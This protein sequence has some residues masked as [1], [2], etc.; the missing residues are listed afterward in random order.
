MNDIVMPKLSDTMTEGRLVSWKKRVGDEV[1]RGEVI[2]EV[3][4]DKAN[5]ELEAYASGVILELKA[6]PGDLVQVGTVIAVVGKPEEKGA[7][8]P[9]VQAPG[10]ETQGAGQAPEPE[11][12]TEP[13]QVPE[14]KPEKERVAQ[15]KGDES[16]QAAP[17]PAGAKEA[18][19]A[20][21]FPMEGEKQA[22]AAPPVPG[23]DQEQP[24]K[25]AAGATEYIHTRAPAPGKEAPEFT[26]SAA[27]RERAAPVVR[28]RAR[29]LG[30][31]LAQVRGSGPDGRILLQ[32]LEGTAGAEGAAAPAQPRKEPAPAAGPRLVEEVRTMSRLRAAVA[33]TVADSWE[34]IPHFSVTMDILMD[35]AEAIRRQLKQGGMRVT[36]ND[37]IVKGVALA[38]VQYPQLNARYTPDGISYHG[39]VSV[40]VAVGVPE[41]V[42]MPVVHRCHALTLLEIAQES[43]RLVKRARSGALTEQEMN[44]GTFSVSNLGMFGVDCFSAIIHP[45]QAGVLAVGAV[46]DAPVVRSGVLTSAK[47][48]KVTLSADHRVA[49]GAYAAEFLKALKEV[50]ENPVRLLI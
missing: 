32:D 34:H 4:T 25:A 29:E 14:P 45:A 42:L 35:E 3:E 27:G 23:T 50:L 37:V 19:E 6:Q 48:M 44:G 17:P 40:S 33:K 28:R 8:A 18:K 13:E 36:V 9:Q 7:P 26:P 30:M 16:S 20:D 22:P 21:I 5:M 1:R 41:G 47:V 2:A 46:L 39:E 11:P 31:D 43:E 24:E 38:L 15:E 49:D 12:V 10:K